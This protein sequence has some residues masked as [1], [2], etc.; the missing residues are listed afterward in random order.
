MGVSWLCSAAADGVPPAVSAGRLP[1]RRIC[2]V[3][4]GEF[5]EIA[6]AFWRSAWCLLMIELSL[7]RRMTTIG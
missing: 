7:L 4:R 2:V 5:L 3:Q 1:L 6:A